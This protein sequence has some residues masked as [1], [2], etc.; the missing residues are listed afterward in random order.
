MCPD[1]GE[2][3]FSRKSLMYLSS[4]LPSVHQNI[5]CPVCGLCGFFCCGGL[6]TV[7][8]LLEVA[9][10]W[11]GWLPGPNLCHGCQ[12]QIVVWS[13]RQHVAETQAILG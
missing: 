3:T 9:G 2:M 6:T 5:G 12:L 4:T 11:S 7:G 10:S 8:S 13:T 1:I